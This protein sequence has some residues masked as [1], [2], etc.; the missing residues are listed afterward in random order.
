MRWDVRDYY[1]RLRRR[2][3]RLRAIKVWQLLV[4]LLL[5]AIVAATG[6]RINNL[7]MIDRVDA[8]TEADK[9]GD[10]AAIQKTITELR[11]YVAS[12]M[13]TD[14]SGGIFLTHSYNRDFE[15]AAAAAQNQSNS[16]SEIYQQASIEC[17]SRWR[18]GVESFRNDYVACV[19]EKVSA[20]GGS[21]DIMSQMN[22][23]NS[24]V[25]KI[26]MI[27]PLWSPDLAGFSILFCTIIILAILFRL[28]GVVVLKLLLKRR[29]SRV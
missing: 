1:A 4:L 8:V 12:H 20:A 24:E 10:P 19:D 21:V 28:T 5:G 15:A 2:L 3:K 23:P 7:G 18:G 29:F 6:L 13:N 27:S 26:N 25:Y 9:G 22:L 14:L 11:R 16:S 17:R